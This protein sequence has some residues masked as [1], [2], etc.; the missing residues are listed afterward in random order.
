ML[1]SHRGECA[2]G[3]LI[4]PGRLTDSNFLSK[5]NKLGR[6]AGNNSWFATAHFL[7][8]PRLGGRTIG[9]TSASGTFE[10]LL[11]HA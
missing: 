8:L 1:Q 7:R 6:E 4:I 2:E 10:L 5:V 3:F 9:S 11:E